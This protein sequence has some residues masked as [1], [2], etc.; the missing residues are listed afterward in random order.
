MRHIGRH[1]GRYTLGEKGGIPTYKPLGRRIYR[2]YL[3]GCIGGYI[4]RVYLSGCVEYPG[5]TSQGVQQ[6]C[7]SPR[8]Y[9]SGCTTV[10]YTKVREVYNSGIP[11]VWKERDTSAQTALR[12]WEKGAPSAQTA[13]LFPVSL[14]GN[15]APSCATLLS[16]AGL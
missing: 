15:P 14:L 13:L 1:I 12:P 3:S 7:I 16:V 5:C 4:P 2:V 6:W 9:L 8:V 10:V 11:R